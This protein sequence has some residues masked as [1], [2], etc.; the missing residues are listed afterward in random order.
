MLAAPGRPDPLSTLKNCFKFNRI[1]LAPLAEAACR[2]RARASRLDLVKTHSLIF[3]YRRASEHTRPKRGR[4]RRHRAHDDWSSSCWRDRPLSQN[5]LQSLAMSRYSPPYYSQ[6]APDQM[7]YSM[8]DCTSDRS[9]SLRSLPFPLI[10]SF[11]QMALSS[12]S[13]STHSTLTQSFFTFK[14]LFR[15]NRSLPGWLLILLLT[16]LRLNSC[17]SDSKYNSLTNILSSL[18]TL[19]LSKACYCHIRQLRSIQAYL[20]SSTACYIATSIVHFKRDYCN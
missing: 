11:M 2:R 19:H 14:T 3:L 8:R 17:S 1:R 5:L 16:L 6:H 9:D 20:D 4:R 13:F 15:P 7:Y 10:T 12:A 18:T